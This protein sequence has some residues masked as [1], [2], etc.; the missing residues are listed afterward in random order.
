LS[1]PEKPEVTVIG[2]LPEPASAV[3]AIVSGAA[4]GMDRPSNGIRT[5]RSPLVSTTAPVA[6]A[7]N[8]ASVRSAEIVISCSWPARIVKRSGLAV[9]SNPGGWSTL[10][11]QRDARGSTLRRVRVVVRVPT[12]SLIEIVG[13]FRSSGEIVGMSPLTM[14]G[15]TA[16]R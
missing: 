6:Y 9:T 4:T 16:S 3:T 1:V 15:S 2:S 10:T 5:R 7:S 12:I 11:V 13:R 8:G 14:S